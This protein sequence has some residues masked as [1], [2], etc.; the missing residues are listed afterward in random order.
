MKLRYGN[1][2]IDFFDNPPDR[3]L[4]SLSGGLDSASLF[5]LICTHFPDME[6]VPFTGRD[7]NAPF[8]A[9]LAADITQ[10]MKERFPKQHI[11]P[12]EEFSYDHNDPYWYQLAIDKWEDYFVLV[13]G[14]K[15]PRCNR[16][17][18]LSKM[19][20]ID[21]QTRKLRQKYDQPLVVTG[22]TSNP[23]IRE[24]KK[25]KFYDLAERRRD[26]NNKDKHQY[27]TFIYMPFIHVD[28]KFVAD[29]YKKNKL[30]EELYPLTG[31]CIGSKHETNYFTEECRKCFGA[32]KRNGRSD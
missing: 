11:L 15:V 25:H 19:M 28:K 14:K 31:S 7:L 27:G 18:G 26:K 24:Q 30:M 12:R 4:L 9:E 6:I 32:T 1:Q 10:W 17:S 22:Q 13:N 21:N 23:P 29:V 8:D 16:T 2:T 5:F 20:Q 3:I